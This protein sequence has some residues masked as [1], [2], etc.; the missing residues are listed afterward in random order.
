MADSI[1]HRGP[2]GFGEWTDPA[3]GIALAH[4]RLAI[5]DVSPAGAQP[6]C[7]A[8]GRWV[9]AFN[10]EIYNF[11]LLRRELN[12]VQPRHWRGH[13]DTEVML[14]AIESYG[15]LEA[16]RRFE[17]MFAFAAWDRETRTLWLARDRAGEKPLYY[18]WHRDRFL[19]GSELKALRMAPG[20]QHH[21]DPHAATAMLRF[22][23]V[24][25]PASILQGIAKLMPGTVLQVD[26]SAIGSRATP[27]AQPFWTLADA[28][29][30]GAAAPFTGSDTEAID[31]LETLLR[32]A[33]GRQMVSDVPLGAFLSGGIDSSTIV[34]L[35]QVQS[36]QP[37]RTFA[38][39]FSEPA[40]DEA[41]H[42]K[43]V[44]AHLGTD[45]TELYVTPKDALGV[46]PRLPTLYDEPF[47]DSSQL[48]TVLVAELARRSVTVSLSGD[49][50]DELFGGY[51]RYFIGQRLWGN[52]ARVPR[53]IRRV[54]AGVMRAVS[55][56]TWDRVL[57]P[58]HPVLPR[59]LRRQ[60]LGM[61]L[62]KV[63]GAL[64]SPSFE[65]F[66]TGLVSQETE[67]S[68]LTHQREGS[69][70]LDQ[71]DRWPADLSG[72]SWMMALDFLSY[73]PDDILVKVDR[74]AM[75]ASLE[76]RVPFLDPRVI[77]F[78]WRLPLHMRVRGETGKWLLR[79]VLGRYVPRSITDRPKQGFGVPVERWLRGE[80]ASWASGLLDPARVS[81]HGVLDAAVIGHEWAIHRAG[82]ANRH[83]VLWP[84]LMLQAWLEDANL[85]V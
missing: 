74:A 85:S 64:E 33:V 82:T 56:D 55:P 9:I 69:S 66:Y 7:S 24:P 22:G 79:Q 2:D 72:I 14:A 67:P 45:H 13:S 1:R 59:V 70:I 60:D 30:R 49:A 23:Y 51:Q 20:A 28:V 17:G 31:A 40:Y 41:P 47:A 81:Q 12:T 75:G 44:A 21:V 77:E 19:F 35:M 18:G 5:I 80:L 32:D 10:G 48:P 25:A 76:T 53:P 62:V 16:C 26:Q 58:L 71:C 39:G 4:R 78:A 73:L 83:L 57:A 34:A 3:A 65:H 6:M 50:G 42:A 84:A 38:I 29:A 36:A 37:V 15:V 27:A 8:S 68:R 61:K 46:I 52:I 43:R 63:A 54:A 11:E